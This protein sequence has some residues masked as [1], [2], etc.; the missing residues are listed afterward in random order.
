MKFHIYILYMCIYI[1]MYI[2]TYVYTYDK[3]IIIGKKFPIFFIWSL[4]EHIIWR[5]TVM[6]YS[7]SRDS[8]LKNLGLP[9]HIFIPFWSHFHVLILK[10]HAVAV[11]HLTVTLQMM[12]NSCRSLCKWWVTRRRSAL[13]I[14]AHIPIDQACGRYCYD[15]RKFLKVAEII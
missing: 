7:I 2:Y 4:S 13:V 14:F 5:F 6:K 12:S 9:E 3:R 1:Y 8:D 15:R 11:S 10:K